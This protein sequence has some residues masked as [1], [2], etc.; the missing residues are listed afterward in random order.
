[1]SNHHSSHNQIRNYNDK[2]SSAQNKEKFSITSKD[3]TDLTAEEESLENRAK[4]YDFTMGIVILQ[5]YQKNTKLRSKYAK[6]IFNY[7]CW[8]SAG[9]FLIILLQGF[10]FLWF[11]LD[12]AAI[13]TLIGGFAIS[14]IS[15]VKIIL[16]GLFLSEEK[17]MIEQIK[18]HLP[19]FNNKDK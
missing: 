16:K 11:K 7:L 4:E 5:R 8:F 14:V 15:L 6:K 13:T 18:N 17:T 9:C 2:I 12:K 19:F 1:M 3:N 10:G